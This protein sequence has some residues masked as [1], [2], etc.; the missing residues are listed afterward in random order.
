MENIL[1]NK[2]SQTDNNINLLPEDSNC[3]SSFKKFNKENELYDFKSESSLDKADKD[4]NSKLLNEIKTEISTNEIKEKY[5]EENS[6]NEIDFESQIPNRN[7]PNM[8][9]SDGIL[10]TLKNRTFGKLDFFKELHLRNSIDT[11]ENSENTQK[12]NFSS[13]SNN[14]RVINNK[15]DITSPKNR[16]AEVPYTEYI[17]PYDSNYISNKNSTSLGK[18]FHR[19]I[20]EPKYLSPQLNPVNKRGFP[21]KCLEKEQNLEMIKMK[22][23]GTRTEQMI[24]QKFNPLQNFRPNKNLGEFKTPQLKFKL[25]SDNPKAMSYKSKSANNTN[26]NSKVN[27]KLNSGSVIM[28]DKPEDEMIKNFDKAVD[29]ANF[30]ITSS[31]YDKFEGNFQVI[32]MSQIGSRKLQKAMDNSEN[33][34]L[35]KISYEVS[36]SY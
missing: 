8:T 21:D 18:A 24:K 11:L 30:E 19:D 25:T 10:E 14:C 16:S 31:I 36:H 32:S 26:P 9:S 17:N 35:N 22:L 27:S 2:N 28:L 33:S 20:V 29:E 34:V 3:E 5:V 23:I 12:V 13:S 1:N 7:K 4:D 6:K 15:S